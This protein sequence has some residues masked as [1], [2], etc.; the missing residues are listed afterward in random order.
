MENLLFRTVEAPVDVIGD[1]RTLVGLVA[2]YGRVAEVDDGFGPYRE[3]IDRGAFAGVMRA[4]P[5]KIK[6][7]LLHRGDWVGRGYQW[8]D[9]DDGLRMVLRLDDTEPGRVAAYKVRDGQTPGLSLGFLAGKSRTLVDAEGV[10]VVHRER[11][12][13]VDHV[14]LC[15]AP[16]YAD[17]TVESLRSAPVARVAER[18]EY[19]RVYAERLRRV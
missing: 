18:V 9:G 13:F 6:V 17:A 12:K 3:V 1:G 14:A 19:W 16:A 4:E 10:P 7:Q 11:I 8:H 5:R 2:P 15:E